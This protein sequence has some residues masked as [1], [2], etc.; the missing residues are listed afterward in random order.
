LCKF[1]AFENTKT[2]TARTQCNVV[3]AECRM[4]RRET[5]C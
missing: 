1:R 4:I 5:G 2:T 3:F